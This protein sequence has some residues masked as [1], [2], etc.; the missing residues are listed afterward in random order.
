MR[1]RE[2]E[3]EIDGKKKWEVALEEEIKKKNGGELK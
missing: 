1:A 3:R 2:R